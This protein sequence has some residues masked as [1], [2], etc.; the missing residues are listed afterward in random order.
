MEIVAWIIAHFTDILLVIATIVAI[1]YLLKTGQIKKLRQIAFKL[2]TDAEQ[3][4]G[5]GT[6]EL[7]FSA[8]AET[9]Y[10]Y[11][12]AALKPFITAKDIAK[13]IE[14]VLEKAKEAWAKSA[15]L[16]AYTTPP[17]SEANGESES[18]G[19][20]ETTPLSQPLPVETSLPCTIDDL[21][22]MITDAVE[23]AMK[24]EKKPVAKKAAKKE[25]KEEKKEDDKKEAK[26]GIPKDSCSPA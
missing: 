25:T 6:G 2:V 21:K 4:Y 11:I 20:F 9:L 12:P 7:K 24:P 3:Q 10:S 22:V 15:E 5:G 17:E 14:T 13:L 16:E 18:I 26:G 1:V 19:Y 8:V 23:E